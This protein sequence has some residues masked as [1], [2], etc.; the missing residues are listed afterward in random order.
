VSQGAAIFGDLIQLGGGQLVCEVRF[1]CGAGVD[2]ATATTSE[3]MPVFAI[4]RRLLGA[5]EKQPE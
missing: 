4:S 1:A 5:I 3:P 2:H